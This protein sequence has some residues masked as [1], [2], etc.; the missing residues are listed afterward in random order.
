MSNRKK[1]KELKELRKLSENLKIPI[2]DS[3]TN[4]VEKKLFGPKIEQKL[5]LTS[6]EKIYL[7]VLEAPFSLLMQRY[8]A[9]EKLVDFENEIYATHEELHEELVKLL[10]F[11]GLTDEDEKIAEYV[12][13][14]IDSRG[15]LRIDAN[16]LSEEFNI[17]IEKAQEIID[18]ILNEFSE[19]IKQYSS[20]SWEDVQYVIPDVEITAEKVEVRKIEVK[21]PVIAKAISMR[22]ETLRKICELVRKSNEYFLRGYRKYPQTLTMKY[23]A[24]MLDLHISTVSRAVKGKYVNTPIGLL[25]LRLFF[26][27]IINSELIKKEIKELLNVD[28]KLTDEQLTLLLNSMGLTISRR[29]V[30]KYR[31]E[32]KKKEKLN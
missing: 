24:N 31:N 11:I 9:K 18:L 8:G 1:S 6:I 29:T 5:I 25:P 16:E 23:V 15:F 2:S 28:E 30:N 7:K 22:E 3:V 26:G 20:N 12:I 21:D 32:L 19:E 17:S 14:N 10:P 13:Y 4:P 27:R